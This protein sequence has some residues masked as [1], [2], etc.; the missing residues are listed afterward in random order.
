MTTL[1]RAI[2]VLLCTVCLT[3][4]AE[5]SLPTPILT[6]FYD[7]SEQ[8]FGM[9]WMS[10]GAVFDYILEVNEF[11]GLGWFTVA[12]WVAPAKISVMSGYTY[13]QWDNSAIARVRIR[14]TQPVPLPRD[15]KR[16]RIFS[17]E[18]F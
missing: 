13:I 14:K 4:Q 16:W 5:D 10:S 2:A 9:W 1:T 11:D 15:N 12:T 8:V 7:F 6:T 18:E 3:S 17:P